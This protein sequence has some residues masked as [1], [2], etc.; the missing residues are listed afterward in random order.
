MGYYEDLAK[1]M[2]DEELNSV[3]GRR[4]PYRRYKPQFSGSLVHIK[5]EEEELLK[6][7]EEEGDLDEA[8]K[9]FLR[10][11]TRRAGSDKEKS[12]EWIIRH[13]KKLEEEGR[14]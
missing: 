10:K 13:I 5:S 1:E 6:Q 4:I 14:I 7:I 3:L 12:Q 8:T 2:S 11:M 9:K